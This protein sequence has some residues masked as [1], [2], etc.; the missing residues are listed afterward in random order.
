MAVVGA[1]LV[2][3]GAVGITAAVLADLGRWPYYGGAVALVIGVALLLSRVLRHRAALGGACLAVAVVVGG[4]AW[5]GLNGLP[6]QHSAW[7]QEGGSVDYRVAGDAAR[8]GDLWFTGAAAYEIS[9]GEVRWTGWGTGAPPSGAEDIRLIA[10]TPT[11]VVSFEPSTQDR[12]SGQLVAR[13]PADGSTLWSVPS[14]I[15]RGSAVDGD[16]LVVTSSEG[17]T[18]H[19]LSTGETVWTSPDGS[20]ASCELGELRHSYGPSPSQSVVLLSGEGR[21]ARADVV[22]VSDGKVLVEDLSCLLS[23]RVVGDVIVQADDSRLVARSTEDGT[24]VWWTPEHITLGSH[25]NVSGNGSTIFTPDG[26]KDYFAIDV[27]TGDV[28]ETSPPR[29]WRVARDET[30]RQVGEHVWQPVVREQGG[31]GMWELGTDRVV[32]VPGPRI[33]RSLES[34]PTSGWLVVSGHVEDPVGDDHPQAWALSPE[35]DLHG[36]FTGRSAYAEDGVIMVDS[37]VHPLE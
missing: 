2:I 6:E 19:G 26:S 14:P 17:T 22:R 31:L 21:G 32:P 20:A 30:R 35:G 4:G 36:P 1:G 10:V 12:Y 8:Q 28:S 9:T 15:V 7:P 34:D 33:H 13:A 27:A 37:T 24:A 18:A 25:Y 29:G 16:A 5:L 11:M 3:V 23:A